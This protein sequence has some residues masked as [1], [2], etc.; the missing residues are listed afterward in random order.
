RWIQVENNSII[1]SFVAQ[2]QHWPSSYKTELLA[3]LL[4]ISI[5]SR[6]C[7]VDIYTDSQSVIFKYQKLTQT[8]TNLSYHYSYNNWPIW[9]TLFNLIKS[10]KLIILFHKVIA[11]SENELNNMANTLTQNHQILLLLE[12]KHTNLYNSN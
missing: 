3:I 10:Y 4:A 9:H 11:H 8:I 5:A 1:N 12:F 6:N 2:V 7:K